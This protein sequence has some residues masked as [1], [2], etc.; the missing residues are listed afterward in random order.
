M[1]RRAD[2]TILPTCCAILAAMAS[3]VVGTVQAGPDVAPIRPRYGPGA[4]QRLAS[5][6]KVVGRGSNQPKK[7]AIVCGV[8]LRIAIAPLCISA[9]RP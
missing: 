4:A 5:F 8:P 7:P 1:E 3:V 9:G 2:C 6:G